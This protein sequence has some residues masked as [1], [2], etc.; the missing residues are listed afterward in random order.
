MLHSEVPWNNLKNPTMLLKSRKT[1]SYSIPNCWK[2][3]NRK[4]Y[5]NEIT[6]APEIFQR[7][8]NCKTIPTYIVQILERS[9]IFKKIK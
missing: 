7:K 5:I 8:T 4:E 3:I 6:V 1:P 9:R 2:A